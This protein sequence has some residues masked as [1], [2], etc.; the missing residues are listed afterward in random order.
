MTV[1]IK[2]FFLHMNK[3]FLSKPCFTYVVICTQYDHRFRLSASKLQCWFCHF[4]NRIP[5]I[6]L[7]YYIIFIVYKTGIIVSFRVL[8]IEDRYLITSISV[9]L[10]AFNWAFPSYL[11]NSI[12]KTNSKEF[13]YLPLTH[14]LMFSSTI[15]ILIIINVN[16]ILPYLRSN[17]R[18]QIL[19][20]DLNFNSIFG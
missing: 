4:N 20:F 3:T 19:K 13:L 6:M 10:R 14:G 1:I 17:S 15:H 8:T 12:Q 16:C 5:E 18:I 2:D 11:L 7:D 9:M